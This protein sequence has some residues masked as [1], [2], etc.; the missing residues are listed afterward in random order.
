MHLIQLF[1]PLTDNEGKAFRKELFHAV[2][3]ELTHQFGGVRSYVRAPAKGLWKETEDNT[4]RD[5]I[6]LIEVMSD[7]IDTS[8]WNAYKLKLKDLFQQ[9]EIIIRTCPIQLL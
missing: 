6:I 7:A 9:I 3:E 5:E 4:I 8:Y 1:L 2:E